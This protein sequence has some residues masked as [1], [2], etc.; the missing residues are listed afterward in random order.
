M[1]QQM[2][3]YPFNG[4]GFA[5]GARPAPKC[6]QPVTP[7][8]YKML[9]QQGNE[10]DIR[11]SNVDKVKNWCTHKEPSTGRM[12]LVENP[13][14]GTVTCRIC[15]ETFRIVDDTD[16]EVQAATDHMVD[17]LQ[18]IKAC[19]VDAPEEFIKQY[20]QT[21]SMVRKVP[22]LY[23][24]GNKNF[25]LYESYT[26]QAVPSAPGYNTFAAMNGILNG[27]NPM[28][29]GWGMPQQPWGAQPAPQAWPMTGQPMGQPQMAQPGMAQ[30][31]MVNPG[32]PWNMGQQACGTWATPPQGQAT[33]PYIDPQG[34]VMP[35]YPNGPTT[36]GGNPMA[37]GFNPLMATG[38]PGAMAAPVPTGPAQP[39]QAA[40]AAGEPTQTKQMVV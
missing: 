30:P 27:F 11:I 7:E 39:A 19:Y 12:A 16:A 29:G 34:N 35:G 20:S 24:R 32:A 4:N 37:P 33:M 36:M 3:N 28:M 31:Q 8:L 25:S 14:D 38:A 15:G 40:P 5:Y 23:K 22:D 2:N 17:I 10:L 1:Y 6:T 13:S 21:L 9:N 26:G 18:T